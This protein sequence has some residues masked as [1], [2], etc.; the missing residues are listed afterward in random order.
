MKTSLSNA[1]QNFFALHAKVIEDKETVIVC[2][3]VR[4]VA[5]ID[6]T[7]LEMLRAR[8]IRPRPRDLTRICV[9]LEKAERRYPTAEEVLREV[10]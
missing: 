4:D 2:S 3:G 5:W 1:L 10:T 6:A 9:A 8:A 7:E